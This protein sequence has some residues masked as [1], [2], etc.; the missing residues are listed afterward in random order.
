[1]SGSKIL[2]LFEDSGSSLWAGTDN[3]LYRYNQKE[4]R[5]ISFFDPLAEINSFAIEGIIE[6]NSK[7]LL[8]KSDSAIIKL[9]PLTKETFIYGGRF[10]IRPNSMFFFGGI[11]KNRQGQIY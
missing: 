6:D 7:D 5:F 3:G 4:D 8:L 1:M 9:N 11:Y 10:G 2:S